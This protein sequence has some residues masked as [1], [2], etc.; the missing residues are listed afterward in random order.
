MVIQELNLHVL[1]HFNKKERKV[2]QV[3][4]ENMGNLDHED[5]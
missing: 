5:L 4:M 1:H 2:I 3:E